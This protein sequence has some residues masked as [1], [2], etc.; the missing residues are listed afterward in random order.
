MF[1]IYKR[2]RKMENG[3]GGGVWDAQQP[4]ADLT[5]VKRQI[6]DKR[7]FFREKNAFMFNSGWQRGYIYKNWFE[8]RLWRVCVCACFSSPAEGRAQEVASSSRVFDFNIRMPPKKKLLF[9]ELLKIKDV[10]DGCSGRNRSTSSR[11]NSNDLISLYVHFLASLFFVHNK[12]PRRCSRSFSVAPYR[13][14]STFQPLFIKKNLFGA[15]AGSCR[16][17]AWRFIYIM[18]CEIE[19]KQ[20]RTNKIKKL[21]I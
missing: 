3:I 13:F 21:C 5:P 19:K 11:P 12:W 17:R 14:A 16:R 20:S 4:P 2:N 8:L 18:R 1:N 15:V 7:F 6:M 10:E 9:C